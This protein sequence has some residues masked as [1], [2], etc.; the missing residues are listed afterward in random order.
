MVWASQF[1][2]CLTGLWCK[3]ISS[4]PGFNF[5]EPKRANV[6]PIRNSGVGLRNSIARLLRCMSASRR[7]THISTKP[8]LKSHFLKHVFLAKSTK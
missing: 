1:Q 4:E 7:K 5:V 8:E 2:V 6:E 3:R